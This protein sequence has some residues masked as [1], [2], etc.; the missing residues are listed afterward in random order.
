MVNKVIIIHENFFRE[1]R[2][3][4]IDLFRE[5]GLKVELWSLYYIKY[6]K[7]SNIPIPADGRKDKVVYLQSYIE[8]IYRILK[9][10]RSNAVFFFTTITHRN[11]IEDFIRIVIGMTRHKYCDL[12]HEMCP[13]GRIQ[14]KGA[15]KRKSI[16]EKIKG[17]I[18]GKYLWYKGK[19][20]QAVIKHLCPPMYIFISTHYAWRNILLSWELNKAI[21]I[22]NKNYDEY[23]L[24]KRESRKYND[25]KYIVYIDDDLCNAEDFR[26]TGRIPIYAEEKLF[27]S[28]ILRTF[29]LIEEYYNMKIVIAAHPKAEYKGDEFGKREIVYYRTRELVE[30]AQLVLTH[31]TTAID[32]VVLYKKPFIFLV[33]K[34]IKADMIWEYLVLPMIEELHINAYDFGNEQNLMPWNYINYP[35][36]YYD[37]YCRN[38]INETSEENTKLFFE[39]VYDYITSENKNRG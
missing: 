2:D 4:G 23:I 21:A 17:K 28:N 15:S 13:V 7:K 1:H 12:C 16:L 30:N 19:I 32:F 24:A 34:Y 9:E 35:S 29:D 8:I 38:F 14:L 37:I 11:G 39:T 3:M 25:E 26:K 10:K 5:K 36:K 18:K 31:N 22:H 20:Y 33:D 6:R 27:Y